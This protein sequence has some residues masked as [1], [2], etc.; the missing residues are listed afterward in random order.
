MLKYKLLTLFCAF[1]FITIAQTATL[2]GHVFDQEH[3]DRLASVNI[4]IYQNDKLVLGGNKTD[5]N[6]NYKINLPKSG[7]YKVE[8]SRPAYQTMTTTI[9]IEKGSSTDMALPLTHL[10]DFEFTGMLKRFVKKGEVLGEGV[11]N[12]R[13]EIYNK[14]KDEESLVKMVNSSSHFVHHFERENRYIVLIRKEGFFPKRFDVVVDQDGCT[15]CFEGLDLN[16]LSGI[17]DNHTPTELSASISGDIS[18]REIKLNEIIEIENIYY[19]FD[20]ANIKPSAKP[21]LDNLVNVMRTSPI[22]IELGSHTDSRGDDEYNMK[23][24]QERAQSAV[25]YIVS[26]GISKDRITAKGYGESRLTYA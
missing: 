23:L 21:A 19:K 25:D 5:L 1:S 24:S 8:L 14:T 11:N 17:F 26:K 12:T 10:P 2:Q 6:G 16:R 22:I 4:D 13:I 9:N 20:K 7:E 3:E 15:I 18:M